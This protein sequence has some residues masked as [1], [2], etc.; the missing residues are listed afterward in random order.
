MQR[1]VLTHTA[2]KKHA[3]LWCPY[4]SNI[5]S[6]LRK[7]CLSKHNEEYP[8]KVRQP[9]SSKRR[10]AVKRKADASADVSVLLDDDVSDQHVQLC[11][12]IGGQS[13][14]EQHVFYMNDSSAGECDKGKLVDAAVRVV[15]FLPW[16]VITGDFTMILPAGK[17][18]LVHGKKWQKLNMNITSFLALLD[19][20]VFIF[21]PFAV[22]SFAY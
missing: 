22:I 16:G 15:K 14:Q 5:D 3:C 12:L 13:Q 2:E 4:R 9:V 6:N 18:T 17:N 11:T 10:T 21:A 8:P 20:S 7:H 19:H 1:H